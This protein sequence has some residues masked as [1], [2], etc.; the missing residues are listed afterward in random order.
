MALGRFEGFG[1]S[2]MEHGIGVI[3]YDQ[4]GSGYSDSIGGRR[5]Y[6]E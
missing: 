2:L 3:A 6:F 4:V 1:N 5:Q